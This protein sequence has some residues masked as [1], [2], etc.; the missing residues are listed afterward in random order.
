MDN[1]DPARVRPGQDV[2]DL[3]PVKQDPPDTSTTQD[4]VIDCRSNQS[5]RLASVLTGALTF[6]RRVREKRRNRNALLGLSD[7]T[8]KDIGISRGQIDGDFDRYRRSQ[9]HGL[10]R[11]TV[12]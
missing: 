12:L 3:F 5:R 10:E 8:L 4:A 9:S 7:Q 1:Y 11:L 6:F 2:L